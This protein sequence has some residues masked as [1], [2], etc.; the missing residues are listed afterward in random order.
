MPLRLPGC[1]PIAAPKC[2]SASMRKAAAEDA[3]LALGGRPRIRVA[4]FP[5]HDHVVMD[6]VLAAFT[7]DQ[8]PV[9]GAIMLP[10]RPA[11]YF[12]GHARRSQRCPGRTLRR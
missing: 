11:G 1:R 5:R 4:H 2:C 10:T 6:D 7:R 9:T 3:A 12:T 8:V